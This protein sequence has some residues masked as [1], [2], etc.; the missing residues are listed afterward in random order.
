MKPTRIRKTMLPMALLAAAAAI[1][2]GNSAPGIRP[3]RLVP[4]A[5]AAEEPRVI[6]IRAKKFEF[7]PSEI[8]LKRGEP[9]VLRLTSEDRTHGFFLKP[10]RIDADIVPGKAT[11]VAVTPDAAG[12]YSVICDHYCG[13]GHGNMKMKLSVVQ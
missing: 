6:E 7:S 2:I 3:A 1:Q 10:L 8:T 4:S 13:T 9:V 12:E 5:D 11:D